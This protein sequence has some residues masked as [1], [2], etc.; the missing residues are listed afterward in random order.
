MQPLITLAD[1]ESESREM[2]EAT[3]MSYE[4]LHAMI[5]EEYEH[6]MMM[7]ASHSYDED[8]MAYG[9]MI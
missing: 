7:Y 5:M 8:A 3:T 6:S 2:L 4:E 9:N 1:L